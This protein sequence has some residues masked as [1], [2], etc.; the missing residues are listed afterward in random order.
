MYVLNRI[1]ENW[2][3]IKNYQVKCI[4]DLVVDRF[5]IIKF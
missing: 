3:E 2:V 1:K 5:G 4:R